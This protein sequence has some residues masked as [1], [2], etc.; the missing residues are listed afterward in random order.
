MDKAIQTLI[1]LGKIQTNRLTKDII[2]NSVF[3]SDYENR[4]GID[5]HIVSDFADGYIEWLCQEFKEEI[6][7]RDDLDTVFKVLIDDLHTCVCV[8]FE[9][10]TAVIRSLD[11]IGIL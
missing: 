9:Q 1:S 10:I 6:V 4:Y 2:W 5:C 3:Y 7:D 11:Y 8:E